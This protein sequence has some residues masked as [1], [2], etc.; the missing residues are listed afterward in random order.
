MCPLGDALQRASGWNRRESPRKRL[1]KQPLDG[2]STSF[3][4]ERCSFGSGRRSGRP[5]PGASALGDGK[6]AEDREHAEGRP[7]GSPGET[8]FG[9]EIG[10]ALTASRTGCSGVRPSGAPAH[11]HRDKQ[12]SA[13]GES[14]PSKEQSPRK[15][16]A[17]SR[18][19]RQHAVTDLTVEQ[20]P[21]VER[22]ITADR[23]RHFPFAE[24]PDPARTN[25]EQRREGTDRGV[26]GQTN[27]MSR[28]GRTNQ[29][30]PGES[31]TDRDADAR[32]D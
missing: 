13:Q 9:R 1:A 15:H 29:V 17:A 16:R 22:P 14:K 20:S 19:K 18:W 4:W 26:P 12:R 24:G 21:E 7:P 2:T 25:R 30:Y 32:H 6:K 28:M 5:R 23:A 3:P 8:G 11:R 10:N 31:G 27:A